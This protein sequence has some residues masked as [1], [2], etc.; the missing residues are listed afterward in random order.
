EAKIIK[1]DREKENISLSVKEISESPAQKFQTEHKMGD[2]IT[3]TIKD[4]KDFGLFIKISDNLDGL[5]RKE[6]FGPLEES[7]IKAG[8]EIEAVLVNIDTK[9]NRIRLSIKRLEA[10]K[11]REILD[12]VN[13]T[14]AMTL[15]D[16]LKDQIK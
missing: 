7:E 3:G 2:I 15:G 14:S 11:N 1:I 10:Q 16:I 9:R 8:D 5:V 13:D 6:D 4:L 12:S